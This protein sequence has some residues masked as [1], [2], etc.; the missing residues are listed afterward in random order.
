VG[1]VRAWF[2]YCA[3]IAAIQV[4]GACAD[5]Q[6][7]D[8]SKPSAVD[9]LARQFETVGF[10]DEYDQ[11]RE[12]DRA[13]KWVRPI[14][15]ALIGPLAERYRGAVQRHAGALAPL[16]GLPIAVQPVKSEATNLEIHFVRWDDMERTAAPHAPNPQWLKTIVEESTCMFIFKRNARFEIVWAMIVVST[17]EPVRNTENC[18]LEELTQSLG[19]PNDSELIRGSVFSQRVVAPALIPDDMLIVRALYDPRIPAGASKRETIA[20]ARR[21]LGELRAGLIARGPAALYQPVVR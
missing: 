19:L 12:I 7:Y 16:T 2:G 5:M 20:A 8:P 15:I 3:V 6:G 21:I 11:Q 9:V 10:Y 17:D 18:L 4:L 13:R 14:N 1:R